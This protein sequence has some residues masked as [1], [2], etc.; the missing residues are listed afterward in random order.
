[1]GPTRE[2]DPVAH[3]EEGFAQR[4]AQQIQLAI[5]VQIGCLGVGFKR[6]VEVD[7][8]VDGRRE[9]STASVEQDRNHA[10]DGTCWTTL[11]R[12]S[13]IHTGWEPAS[14]SQ[15]GPAI[16][17]EVTDGD[18]LVRYRLKKHVK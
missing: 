15:V 14:P 3:L 18:E 16:T 5:A 4:P 13:I 11:T 7:D 10:T 8:R 2:V 17:V 12:L 1:V 9:V 6:N